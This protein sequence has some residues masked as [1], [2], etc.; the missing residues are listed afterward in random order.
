MITKR[1]KS[2]VR[3]TL[4]RHLD[5]ASIATTLIALKKNGIIDFIQN[6]KSFNTSI[7]KDNFTF[8]IGY[9]NIALRLLS[10]QGLLIQDI[11][12]DGKNINYIVTYKGKYIFNNIEK[13]TFALEWYNFLSNIDLKKS[14]MDKITYLDKI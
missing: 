13:Y 6:T 12:N 8:N 9:L 4:F 7:L 10:S 3:N 1:K 11:I 5:G 2:L 14:N